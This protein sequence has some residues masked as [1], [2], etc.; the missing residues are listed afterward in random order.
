MKKS[1]SFKWSEELIK[2]LKKAVKK[3]KYRSQTVFVE[4][5]ILE[6]IERDK[7]IIKRFEKESRD[8]WFF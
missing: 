2:A 7:R 6:K 8:V 1:V 3:G 5:A 4:E